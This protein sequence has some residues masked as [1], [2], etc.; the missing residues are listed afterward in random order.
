MLVYVDFLLNFGPGNSLIYNLHNCPG[1]KLTRNL[2]SAFFCLCLQCGKPSHY[3]KALDSMYN[4]A[5][6]KVE[7]LTKRHQKNFTI[8]PQSGNESVCPKEQHKQSRSSPDRDG[9]ID[10]ELQHF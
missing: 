10:N 8:P 7:K 6:V 4:R 9:D 5:K 1:E 3:L 2:H